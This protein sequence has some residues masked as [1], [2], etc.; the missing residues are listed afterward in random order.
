MTAESAGNLTGAQRAAI[1]LLGLGEEGAAAIMR[2][3]EPKEVQRVGEAM[4]GLRDVSN[5]QI[6]TVVQD[7]SEK[8]ASVSPIG[9]GS[10]DFTRR[11]LVEALGEKRAR[12]MLNK[13]MQ[14][15][16]STGMDAL[17]WMDARSVAG[18]IRHEHPQITALVLASLEPD[19]AAQVLALLPMETRPDILMR[20]ARLELVD[21]S[22]LQE[23]DRVLEKQLVG[24]QEAPPTTVD[25]L[26]TAA[27]I[28]NHVDS[29]DESLLLDSM[30]KLDGELGEKI[31]EL[32]FVFEN[33]MALDDRGMQRLIREIATDK[34]VIAL[35]GVDDDLKNKFF[36]NMSSRAADMLKE[37]LEAQGPVKL[38]DVEAQ[39]KEILT[40]AAELA[41][42][43]EIF[44][45]KGG[46]DFV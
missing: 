28:L 42:A 26:N 46:D 27:A 20:I 37:D 45:G 38:A 25:G 13:V 39:Q 1:F 8:I 30:K 35:K 43:G 19:H 12:S 14:D 4:A 3:M 31:Q 16:N 7:F 10:D 33:L 32:M 21:P 6:A 23:L 29:G 22:A 5:E 9:I 15:K 24:D 2:H 41:E 44:L 17:K 40:I 34:L 18:I 36:K 11:V